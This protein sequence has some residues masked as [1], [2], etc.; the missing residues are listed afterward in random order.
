VYPLGSLIMLLQ[1]HPNPYLSCVDLQVLFF[2]N[3]DIQNFN[4]AA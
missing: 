1:Y 4:W 3:Y 2:R